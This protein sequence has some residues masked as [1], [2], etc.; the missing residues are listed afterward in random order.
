MNGMSTKLTTRDFFR[1]PAKVARLVQTGRRIT[2]TRAGEAFFDVTPV[3]RKKGKTLAD[4]KHILFSDKRMDPDASK[5]I[6]EVLY[7]K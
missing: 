4:F 6:D 7:G 3:A 5:K 2:V 1:S